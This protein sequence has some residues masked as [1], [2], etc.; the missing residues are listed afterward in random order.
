[1]PDMSLDFEARLVSVEGDVAHLKAEFQ[2]T[3]EQLMQSNQAT[4][5]LVNDVH[6][7]LKAINAFV[8]GTNTVF[9]FAKKHWQKILYFGCGTMTA[10]G[11]GNPA[12]IHFIEGF[13]GLG[14]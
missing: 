4:Q 11:I 3:K 2:S 9:G 8:T 12:L 13:F 7:Q 14:H 6:E 10:L 1:M 5:A